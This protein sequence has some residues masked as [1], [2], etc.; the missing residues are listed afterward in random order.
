MKLLIFFS[1]FFYTFLSFSQNLNAELKLAKTK[2]TLTNFKVDSLNKIKKDLEKKI[3]SIEIAL[4][5][6]TSAYI[7]RWDWKRIEAGEK[8]KIIKPGNEW[9]IVSTAN[10]K[11]Y[12]VPTYYLE[13]ENEFIERKKINKKEEEKKRP[14]G[15]TI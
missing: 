6:S 8:C 4:F 9:T 14:K 7:V 2:L 3:D 11:N 1:F 15:K 13:K 5:D 12:K 10:I